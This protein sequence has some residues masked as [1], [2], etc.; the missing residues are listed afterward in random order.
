MSKLTPEVHENIIKLI[1]IGVPHKHAAQANGIDES[2]YYNWMKWGSK[3]KNGIYFEF[4]KS[5]KKA[6]SESIARDVAQ[7]EKAASEGRW[8]ASAWR[9]ERRHPEEWGL[10]YEEKIQHSGNIGSDITFR[11]VTKDGDNST[12][13]TPTK[14]TTSNG[15]T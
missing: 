11:F 13:S 14:T 9:L 7:I 8:Q 2:T 12:T 4:F 5:V 15:G 10:K 1:R 3:K 6:E